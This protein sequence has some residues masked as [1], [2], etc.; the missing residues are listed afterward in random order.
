[1][2]CDDKDLWPLPMAVVPGSHILRSCSKCWAPE[3]A[4]Q[5]LTF[6]EKS[7]TDSPGLCRQ[8]EGR[9]P[10]AAIF[11]WRSRDEG[12]P[13]RTLRGNAYQHATRKLHCAYACSS[14]PPSSALLMSLK[15]WKC[16]QRITWG[17]LLPRIHLAF[18][19]TQLTISQETWT[20]TWPK[21]CR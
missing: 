14:V 2:W 6:L 16:F 15:S 20:H 8:T 17:F 21:V 4:F 13:E 18:S 3:R 10:K 19:Y 7:V 11:Q 12:Y 5:V 9:C 1:M